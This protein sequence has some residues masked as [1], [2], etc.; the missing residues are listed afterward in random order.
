MAD[1]IMPDRKKQ[2]S[3]REILVGYY[4]PTEDQFREL[5]DQAII[6][7]DANV[8]LGLYRYSTSTRDELL[9]ILNSVQERLWVPH[10]SALEFE[11]NRIGE[12]R[13]QLGAYESLLK[14]FEAVENDLRT[15]LALR[16]HPVLEPRE[17]QRMVD[18]F[19]A[20]IKKYIETMRGGHPYDGSSGEALMSEAIRDRL[21]VLLKGCVGMPYGQEKLAEVMKE[22]SA[23]YAKE[24]PPGYKDQRKSEPDRYGDLIF[25]LQSVDRAIELKKPLLIVTDDEKEDW[26]W[27]EGGLTVGPRPELIDEFDRRAHGLFYMYTTTRFM[28][29]AREYL[30]RD[31]SEEAIREVEQVARE[32]TDTRVVESM[33]CPVCGTEVKVALGVAVGSSARPRCINCESLFYAHRGRD[34][35]AF[36]SPMIMR[37][38]RCPTCQANIR[39]TQDAQSLSDVTLKKCYSCSAE[40]QL[41]WQTISANRIGTATVYPR[42]EVSKTELACSNCGQVVSVDYRSALGMYGTCQVCDAIVHAS[43]DGS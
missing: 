23:R 34:G 11:R 7:L 12:I 40:L 37:V 25:W 20:A 35:I 27:R 19:S 29:R 16:R 32:R 38:F 43:S 6:A 39:A 36:V 22:G 21:N 17:L 2:A 31:V 4:R 5:W 3:L 26:W 9:G 14:K 18:E 13:S 28:E 15:A 24:T 10:W 41:D 8:L 42:A 33:Q 1:A 30:K